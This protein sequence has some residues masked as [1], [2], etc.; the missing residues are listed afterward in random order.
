MDKQHQ[1]EQLFNAANN[2]QT[3]YSFGDTKKQFLS[4]VVVSTAT[5]KVKKTS[6]LS[7]KNW[8]IMFALISTL[9]ASFILFFGANPTNIKSASTEKTIS[10]VK[11]EHPQKETSEKM[12]NDQTDHPSQ[13]LSN[14]VPTFLPPFEDIF[15]DPVEQKPF[16]PRS[17][18][19]IVSKPLLYEENYVFPKLTEEEI[20]SNKKKKKEMLKALEKFDKKVYAYIPIG[21]FEYEGKTISIQ[22][23]Y[24]QKTEVSNLEYRTFLFDLLIQNRKEEFLKAKPDQSMWTKLFGKENQPMEELYFSHASYNEYPV[25]NV[26]R[27]GV[28]LYCKWLSQELVKFIGDSK[29]E[30]YNDVRIPLHVE[31]VKAAST[32]GTQLPYPWDGIYLRDSKGVYLANFK[33][34]DL[35]LVRKQEY[36]LSYIVRG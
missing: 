33:P 28:E 14:Q 25:V 4:T 20:R 13:L 19:K 18:E 12:N 15:Q 9:T 16:D 27:E 26:S 30:L 8:I 21:S 29:E 5:S 7:T 10:E 17:M 1:L 32:E 34:T 35:N 3:V 11:Q 6:F 23:F 31:W 24:M 2:E 36:K 22:A